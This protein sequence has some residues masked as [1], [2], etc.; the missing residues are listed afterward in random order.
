[1]NRTIQT[2]GD[3]LCWTAFAPII[4]RYRRAAIQRSTSEAYDRRK[5]D[6][7]L[8]QIIIQHGDLLA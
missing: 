4:R 2:A 6:S 3:L 5:I 7:L 1:M 8:N